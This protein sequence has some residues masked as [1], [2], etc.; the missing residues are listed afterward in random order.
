MLLRPASGC[1]LV[2][3]N[4]RELSH[5]HDLDRLHRPKYGC[6]LADTLLNRLVPR[7]SRWA[8]ILGHEC[9]TEGRATDKQNRNNGNPA[10]L[11][12]EQRYAQG[13]LK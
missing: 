12:G 11:S 5:T 2:F 4:F 1:E 6:R 9:L 3:L 13:N 8:D 7:H 10:D